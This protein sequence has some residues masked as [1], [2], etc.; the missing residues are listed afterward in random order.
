MIDVVAT[1]RVPRVWMRGAIGLL[2]ITL[3]MLTTSCTW[4]SRLGV[5]S[6]SEAATLMLRHV[7]KYHYSNVS[8][9]N[10]VSLE[11]L[12]NYLKRLDVQRLCFTAEDIDS[13]RARYGHLLD[14]AIRQGQ[15][16]PAREIYDLYQRR[17]ADRLNFLLGY[18]K[19]RPDLNTARY[20]IPIRNE[21]P[22]PANQADLEQLWQD[23]VRHD[24][25]NLMLEERSYEAARALLH[26]GYDRARE[27]DAF[28][29]GSY[30]EPFMDSF[31]HALD[32]HSHY[33]SRPSPGSA[34][35]ARDRGDLDGRIGITLEDGKN[36]VVVKDV[37]PGGPAAEQ[38]LKP[39]DRIVALEV[40]GDGRLEDVE[41]WSPRDVGR[42]T[43]GSPGTTLVVRVLPAAGESEAYEAPLLRV[44]ASQIYEQAKSLSPDLSSSEDQAGRR[45]PARSTKKI[46]HIDQDGQTL[47]IGVILLRGFDRGSARDVKGLLGE[48]QS[49]GVDGMLLDLRN[50][51]GGRMSE[52]TRII[53]F[54][55][56]KGPVGQVRDRKGRLR[57]KRSAARPAIWDG[58]LAVLVNGGSASG[59]EVLAAAIQDHGRG[60]VVGQRTFGKGSG[61]VRFPIKVGDRGSLSDATMHITTLMVYRATGRSIHFRGIYPDIELPAAGIRWLSLRSLTRESGSLNPDLPANESLLSTAADFRRANAP[62]LQ[63][64]ALAARH[65]QRAS[66]ELQ[67]RLMEEQLELIPR[68]NSRSPVLLNL[69]QRREEQVARCAK[70]L[71]RT[72]AWLEKEGLGAA[73]I[74]PA[75]ADFLRQ[76]KDMLPRCL[77]SSLDEPALLRAL[78]T[79]RGFTL[80]PVGQGYELEPYDLSL[81]QT[82][83]IVA[84]MVRFRVSIA[85][86]AT[87]SFR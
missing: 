37:V 48:L 41:G 1:A 34:L 68:L 57:V 11:T 55:L 76:Q 17:R 39:G 24:F 29:A 27:Y 38:G 36:E 71:E 81:E 56:G 22:W 46:M 28:L 13:F 44:K 14:D 42:L 33:S 20:W 63:V 65:R 7:E 64:A 54:F 21:E 16:G 61:S 15:L 79:A 4:M 83:R 31:A 35:K 6:E 77:A 67:W 74:E 75:Q 18:L 10:R 84:D 47:K 12:E 50:N 19:A 80:L 72:T 45:T 49:E 69:D 51:P 62:Q 25:I 52:T 58:P 26:H 59:S 43:S 85:P 8:V 3:G 82:A 30:F 23:Q 2:G 73:T 32:S 70:E 5:H 87:A 40:Y 9:D 60:L 66:Q 78:V 86:T 53:G